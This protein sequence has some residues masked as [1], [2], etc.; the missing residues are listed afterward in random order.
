MLIIAK[1]ITKEVSTVFVAAM[2]ILFLILLS[3]RFASYLTKAATGELPLGLVFE[4]VLLYT[5]ELF[6]YLLPLSFYIAILLSFS[7][8][9]ADHEMTILKA[10]GIGTTYIVK[11][12]LKLAFVFSLI[13]ALF[14]CYLVPK[15]SQIREKLLA[16]RQNFSLMQ[17]VVPQ[18]FQSASDEHLIFYVEE[19]SKAGLFKGVFIAERPVLQTA[20]TDQWVFMTAEAAEIKSESMDKDQEKEDYIVLKNGYRY[21]GLPGRADYRVIAFEE[22]GRALSLNKTPV[23]LPDQWRLKTS[24]DLL[25]L[26]DPQASAEWQWRLSLPLSVMI[27][28]VM[29]IPLS[30]VNP[31]QGRFS[32]LGLAII[33]YVL[34][35]N[36]FTVCRRWVAAGVLPAFIGS[37]WVHGLFLILASWF[38][39]HD[40]RSLKN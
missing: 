12:V 5:P 32:R 38:I 1:Y 21:Q 29:A 33:L 30:R 35:Y 26:K 22:Y 40:R 23:D 2:S 28:A 3:N 4:M 15:S 27:L 19:V 14:T 11:L 34:Y 39:A 16:A 9:Y 18:R 10:C 20:E 25:K 13:T 24:L 8:L 7:R 36:L 6:T 31:R 37:W 17:S